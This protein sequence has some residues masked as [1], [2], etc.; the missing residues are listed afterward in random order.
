MNADLIQHLLLDRAL[1]AA[2]ALV[3]LTVLATG[4]ALLWRRAG[5]S[6]CPEN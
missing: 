3:A 4:M 6:R 5:K 1:K 2:I